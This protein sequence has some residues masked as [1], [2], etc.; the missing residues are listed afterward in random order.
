MTQFSPEVDCLIFISFGKFREKPTSETSSK[1][2][3]LLEDARKRG[4]KILGL[5][6]TLGRYD[7]VLIFEALNEK[8]AMRFRLEAAGIVATETMVAIPKDEAAKL[9]ERK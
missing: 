4:I 1:A 2:T 8:E 5:Y 7:T 6:W 3:K 9:L